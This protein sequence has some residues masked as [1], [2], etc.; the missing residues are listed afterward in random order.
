MRAASLRYPISIIRY[1]ANTFKRYTQPIGQQLGER[2]FMALATTHSAHNQIYIS[3]IADCQFHPFARNAAS[4]FDVICDA[5][6]AKPAKIRSFRF[7]IRETSPVR[8]IKGIIHSRLVLPAVVCTTNSCGKRHCIRTDQ[9]SSAQFY[10][11]EAAGIRCQVDQPFDYV[12]SLRPAGTPINGRRCSIGQNGMPLEIH[13]R[14]AIDALH[15]GQS[16]T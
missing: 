1:E 13:T 14:N 8:M 12:D 4:N 11:I 15:H 16:F 10:T 2:S 5:D 7:T 3:I 6:T 9:I